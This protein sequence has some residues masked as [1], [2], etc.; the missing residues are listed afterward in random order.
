MSQ[1]SKGLYN[2]IVTWFVIV[3]I[4]IIGVF[5]YVET[6]AADERTFT[7]FGL[8]DYNNSWFWVKEDGTRERLTLPCELD[9]EPGE[10]IVLQNVLRMPRGTTYLSFSTTKHDI[11]VYVDGVF[12]YEYNTKDT[13]V[14]GNNSVSIVAFVPILSTDFG[15]TITIK[16]RG[17]NNYSGV[18]DS[19]EMGSSFGIFAD[20]ARRDGIEVILAMLLMFFGMCAALF[21]AFALFAYKKHL[22]VGFLGWASFFAG[23]WVIASSDFKQFIAPNFSMLANMTYISMMV[24]PFCV[25]LYFDSI[26]E[27]RYRFLYLFICGV[28]TFDIIISLHLTISNLAE[29]VDLMPASFNLIGLAVIIFTITTIIDIV[30]RRVKHYLIEI[31]GSIAAVISMTLQIMNYYSHPIDMNAKILSIGLVVLII[32][33]LLRAFHDTRV[34]EKDKSEAN[35][36]TQIKERI[37]S[38]ISQ[39]M[40]TPINTVLGMNK[41]ILKECPDQ[42][43]LE[44]ARDVYNAGEYMLELVNEIRDMSNMNSGEMEF[45][46]VEYELMDLIRDCYSKTSVRAKDHRLAYAFEVD[47]NL[48]SVLYGDKV[49]LQQIITILLIS[50]IRYTTSGKVELTVQGK[51]S[52]GQLILIIAVEDTGVGIEPEF[53]PYIFDSFLRPELGDKG[54]IDGTGLGLTIVKQLVELMGGK[55]TAESTKGVGSTFTAIIPQE[56][57]SKEPCGQFSVGSNGDRR[58]Y[59]RSNNSIPLKGRIL[60]VDDVAMDIRVVTQ[61]LKDTR[62]E[63]DSAF[64]GEETI[65]KIQVCKYDLIILDQIMPGMDG[66]EVKAKMDK[67]ETNIN[68]DTPIIILTSSNTPEDI[69]QYKEAG[70]SDYLLKPIR[71][72]ILK[73]LIKDHLPEE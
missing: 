52:G 14:F 33:S 1:A 9:V 22:S 12:R 60:M 35:R 26:Q 28:S 7:E 54:D 17:D 32:A 37:L 8:M 2:L 72:E 36:E 4:T 24:M 3:I 58:A 39:E 51:V 64:S 31:G 15:K 5:I 20:I 70:F 44:Y 21:S 69:R 62:L 65:E 53:L 29:I 10:E 67:M 19:F 55:V 63:V 23:V 61:L 6:Q 57:R 30:K 25:A 41:M 40:R 56:I 50:A 46:P 18:I 38:Q 13:R 71:E 34:L 73:K 43:I 42:S 68:F 11:E 49:R 48:P 47:E 66:F 59:D 45:V 27:G 16:M